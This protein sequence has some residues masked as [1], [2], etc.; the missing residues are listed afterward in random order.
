MKEVVATPFL[1]E[2]V[3]PGVL[4]VKY[5]ADLEDDSLEGVLLGEVG[6]DIK[7]VGVA[8]EVP[9]KEIK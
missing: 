1:F 9:I 4:V 8:W 3:G 7:F 2:L 6:A 5:P